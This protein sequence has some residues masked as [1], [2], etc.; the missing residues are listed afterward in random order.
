VE[1]GAAAAATARVFDWFA[2]GVVVVA[3]LFVAEAWARAAAS[4]GEDVAALVLFWCFVCRVVRHVVHGPSPRV[5]FL[6]K[7]FER[8]E[9]SLDFVSESASQRVSWLA[10]GPDSLLR[11]VLRLNAKA[12]LLAGLF[13]IYF[14]FI[15]LN[16]TR[17]RVW[18][19]LFFALQVI[20]SGLVIES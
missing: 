13:S 10:A 3:E 5:P 4:V 8:R 9:L 12:R 6:C 17:L 16:V 7:V 18:V 20:H 19:G 11:L 2:R 1:G 15:K 14:H